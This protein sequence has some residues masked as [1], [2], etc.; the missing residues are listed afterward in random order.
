MALHSRRYYYL[1]LLIVWKR[2]DYKHLK[3]GISLNL[4][5]DEM[6]RSLSFN[7]FVPTAAIDEKMKV[8]IKA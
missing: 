8:V 3:T 6:G 4:F 7:Y 5:A 1:W 2:I